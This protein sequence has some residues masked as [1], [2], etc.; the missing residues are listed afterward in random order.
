MKSQKI[1][2]IEHFVFETKEE[3]ERYHLSKDGIVPELRYWKDQEVDTGSWVTADDGGIVQILYLKEYIQK[4]FKSRQTWKYKYPRKVMRTVVGT[5][6]NDPGIGRDYNYMPYVMDTD[7]EK[8]PSRYTLSG[9]DTGIQHRKNK[10]RLSKNDRRFIQLYAMGRDPHELIGE[11]WKRCNVNLKYKE[12][13][14]RE[15]I[16]DGIRKEVQSIAKEQGIDDAYILNA[17]KDLIEAAKME[18]VKLDTIVTLG[19]II[20]T[21]ADPK[22]QAL[23]GGG[24]ATL[25]KGF[26][27]ALLEEVNEQ[28]S[29][30]EKEDASKIEDA[31]F[32]EESKPGS[33]SSKAKA[34]K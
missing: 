23:Q 30:K 11:I 12:L 17:L 5:F 6:C 28:P 14:A 32:I 26:D 33:G 34:K 25:F 24:A 15:S 18:H 8:H 22:A 31:E 29:S 3:F 16:L 27:A 20:G 1:K 21:I 2:G 13:M 7:F 9:V 4:M 10:K 19:K